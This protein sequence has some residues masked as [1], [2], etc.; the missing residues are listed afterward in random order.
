VHGSAGDTNVMHSADS[1]KIIN[2]EFLMYSS[3][4]LRAMEESMFFSQVLGK[5]RVFNMCGIILI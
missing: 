1:L 3:Y 4:K 5:T 2:V